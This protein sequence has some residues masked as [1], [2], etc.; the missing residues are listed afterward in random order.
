MQNRIRPSFLSRKKAK[1]RQTD[2]YIHFGFLELKKQNYSEGFE[3]DKRAE[4][5]TSFAYSVNLLRM[6]LKMGLIT[7]DEY[8]KIVKISA[9]HYGTEIICV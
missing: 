4:N 2:K 7:D 6:L 5:N 9:E 8:G 1:C 3:M